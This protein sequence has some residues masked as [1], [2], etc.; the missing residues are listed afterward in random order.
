M[1]MP[2]SKSLRVSSIIHK[3][4]GKVDISLVFGDT[5]TNITDTN[6]IRERRQES[7]G[8]TFV[9]NS[10]FDRFS[11]KTAADKLSSLVE[12]EAEKEVR[13]IV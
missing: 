1:K 10:V 7:G 3:Y 4:H 9:V 8:R 5:V 2:T 11:S 6:I 13:N 12:I